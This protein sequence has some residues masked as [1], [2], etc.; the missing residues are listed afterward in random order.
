MLASNSPTCHFQFRPAT[1][2]KVYFSA[3]QINAAASREPLQK[4]MDGT[5]RSNFQQAAVPDSIS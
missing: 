5:R 4:F 1:I 2:L 3:K